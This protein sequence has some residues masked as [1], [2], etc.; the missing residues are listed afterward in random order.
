MPTPLYM[1]GTRDLRLDF[2]RG[3]AILAMTLTHL[4]MAS[5]LIFVTG[6]SRFLIT[7]ADVFLFISGFT[8]GHIAIGHPLGQQVQNRLA[9]SWLIYRYI[10]FFSLSLTVLLD[11]PWLRTATQGE[12]M[13]WLTRLIVLK[14]ATW[15][16]D[17]LIT[18]VVYVALAP[19]VLWGLATHRTRLVLI[20]TAGIFLL[21]LL[22]PLATHLGFA[23]MEHLALYSP[24]FVGA[25][26]LGYH[27][28]TLARWWQTHRWTR[29]VDRG[30][31]LTGML[32]LGMF[33]AYRSGNEAIRVWLYN[34]PD[35]LLHPPGNPIVVSL[36][37]RVL[38][39]LVT[40]LWHPLRH[41]SGWLL[42]PL[43]QD[44]LFA[45][46]MHVT[47]IELFHRVME[48]YDI[49]DWE[50][51]I[52][53]RLLAETIVVG[54]VWSS[55]R[56]RR[57]LRAV[58]QARHWLAWTRRHLLNLLVWGT[59]LILMGLML[60]TMEPGGWWEGEEYDDFDF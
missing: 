4:G 52:L 12:F 47:A 11:Q 1:D 57:R 28:Y 20:T 29:W 16:M 19:L 37:L 6:G 14:D 45:Y 49:I 17:I 42:I 23:S 46:C 32:L 25:I 38:W 27:R 55:V 33:L 48:S 51:H 58:L 59:L 40:R 3:Y 21:T 39:L 41:V 36:Y 18:Y 44:G 43:G 9:R 10:L 35:W 34:V 13:S 15:D 26:V 54:V 5:P 8:I 50:S 31:M 24:L 60:F 56:L 22:D 7:A 2:L 53:L 30:T